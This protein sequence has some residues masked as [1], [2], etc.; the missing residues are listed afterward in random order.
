MRGCRVRR[1]RRARGP[2]P[3]GF[4][5]I[6]PNNELCYFTRVSPRSL[7]RMRCRKRI[8][9]RDT[10]RRR[11]LPRPGSWRRRQGTGRDAALSGAGRQGRAA[12]VTPR[13]ARD[14]AMRAP[15]P[16]ADRLGR[17]LPLPTPVRGARLPRS[18]V[19]SA[20]PSAPP[21]HA[22]RRARAQRLRSTKPGTFRGIRTTG[23]QKSNTHYWRNG[24]IS[25]FLQALQGSRVL[26]ALRSSAKGEEFVEHPE[27]CSFM[28][29]LPGERR[30]RTQGERY[31]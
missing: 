10:G 23:S 19:A 15:S 28:G 30:G 24:T 3:S 7:R 13:T 26:I 12:R 20:F 4:D 2:C 21:P 6:P 11:A 17:R 18:H 27:G 22:A 14:A 31:A 8:A 5:R 16:C 25:R 29:R 1:E 9:N